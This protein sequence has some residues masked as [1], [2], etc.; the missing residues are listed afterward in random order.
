MICNQYFYTPSWWWTKIKISVY[1]LQIIIRVV[2]TGLHSSFS[3]YNVSFKTANHAKKVW[4]MWQQTDLLGCQQGRIAPVRQHVSSL[5]SLWY[6]QENPNSIWLV[7]SSVKIALSNLPARI[8][9]W[10]IS[11]AEICKVDWSM[12]YNPPA[13]CTKLKSVTMAVSA[14]PSCTMISKLLKADLIFYLCTIIT[15]VH[16]IIILDICF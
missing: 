1:F 10:T 14:Y 13:V 4:H 3:S 11:N 9:E 2:G 8:S 15:Y 16:L 12:F 6:A 5:Y 7:L